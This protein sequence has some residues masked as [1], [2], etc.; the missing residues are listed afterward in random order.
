[1]MSVLNASFSFSSQIWW[2]GSFVFAYM[3]CALFLI[4]AQVH[5]VSPHALCGVFYVC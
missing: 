2:G 5:V 4:S 3:L 1:M